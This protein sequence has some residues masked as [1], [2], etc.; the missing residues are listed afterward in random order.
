MRLKLRTMQSFQFHCYSAE[1]QWYEWLAILVIIVIPASVMICEDMFCIHNHF[2]SWCISIERMCIEWM[3]HTLKGYL[4]NRHVLKGYVLNGC[5]L[6]DM[7]WWCL[8]ICMVW[9]SGTPTILWRTLSRRNVFRKIRP[10]LLWWCVGR[11][12]KTKKLKHNCGHHNVI[13]PHPVFSKAQS[14]RSTT[15]T[16]PNEYFYKLQLT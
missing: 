15:H 14:M 1:Q 4:L 7:N 9:H 11:W 10:T 8:L 2:H 13:I 16:S 6:N 12:K 5:V 3:T